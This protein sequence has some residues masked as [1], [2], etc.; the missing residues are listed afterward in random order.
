MR[1]EIS[2]IMGALAIQSE[3]HSNVLDGIPMMLL[4]VDRELKVVHLNAAAAAMLGR[5]KGQVWGLPLGEV[6]ECA[7]RDVSVGVPESAACAGCAFRQAIDQT[8][9]TGRGVQRQVWALECG[10][11]ATLMR[12]DFLLTT[13]LMK[14]GEGE[15]VM[16]A[17]DDPPQQVRDFD[18]A[19]MAAAKDL[20][21]RNRLLIAS[22][23]LLAELTAIPAHGDI[24]GCIVKGLRR[25]TGA[26]ATSFSSYDEDAK[27]LT[28]RAVD[29]QAGLLQKVVS[30]M[31]RFSDIK[32]PVDEA[33]HREIR[34]QII[35]H[36]DTLSEVSF[37]A[38]PPLIGSVVQRVIGADHFIALAHVID[39]RVYGTSL[40]AMKA[41]RPRPPDAWLESIAHM[42]AVSLRRR[43]AELERAESEQRLS[44]LIEQ[45]P[46]SYELYDVQG[47]LLHANA[48][49]ERLWQIPRAV[50][51][52]RFNLL[53]G[54]SSQA[55]GWSH[56]FARVAAGETVMLPQ[57]EV[58]PSH[59]PEAQ[60]HGRKRWVSTVAYPIKSHKGEVRR[61]VVLHEDITERKR[62]EEERR[63]LHASMAQSDRLASMGMLAAGVAHEINNPLS[64]I[65]MN[66]ENL[67]EV[68]PQHAER[69]AALRAALHEH[70]GE[71]QSNAILGDAAASLD[72][73]TWQVLTERFE[74]ALTGTRKIKDI[75]KGLGTFSHV[76]NDT[77]AA[78]PIGDPIAS[79]LSIAVN[80]IKYRAKIQQELGDTP[81]VL[82]NE[83]KLSQV[84]LNLFI[85]AAHAIREGDV[86]HNVIGVRT[87]CEGE[88]V[89]AEVYDSGQG[90]APEHL[91]QVF[92]PF[93][94][95]KERGVGSGLGLSIARNI[96]EGFGGAIEACSE[97]GT[98][99][100]FIIRLPRAD[101]SASPPSPVP[102]ASPA[103]KR[104][105]RLL[106][107]DDDPSLRAALKH[108]LADHDLVE[109]ESGEAAIELLSEDQG[110]DVILCDMMMPNLSGMD[111]HRWLQGRHPGLAS[112]VVFITGGAFTSSTRAYLRQVD[113]QRLE[114]PIE[115]ERLRQIVAER[116]RLGG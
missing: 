115:T 46:V 72:P 3:N 75:A 101:L 8:F 97:L 114:K 89:C 2:K 67:V 79:A 63:H 44:D 24:A 76:D 60:G 73:Q 4:H 53:V 95:T 20:A 52:G 17:L 84:F 36:R 32:V 45:S 80:E 28:P 15:V 64:Y 57:H 92:Q 88:Q 40:V 23:E 1:S 29:L 11:G 94:T 10:H 69:L 43:H 49:W 19:T 61:I 25:A 9:A 98:G 116:L 22:N 109:V 93:F 62:A 48:A 82:G 107:I 81:P 6:L 34:E 38:I 102:E 16:V 112:K 30:L 85:N 70:L 41:Q 103:P 99:T 59:M 58:D 14:V 108:C 13:S 77:V 66:L 106:L 86:E 111:L 91:E 110:F 26:A 74:H 51:I 21:E 47:N 90:I 65:L 83:G 5:E 100:R 87:W 104:A 68:L 12:R 18:V 56:H 71:G 27:V 78:V 113:N 55:M 35:G 7:N 37:G 54:K 33:A 39:G 42:I 105:G 31:G 96:V 50:G